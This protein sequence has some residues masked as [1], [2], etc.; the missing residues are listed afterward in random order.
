MKQLQCCGARYCWLLEIV[1]QLQ[2]PGFSVFASRSADSQ[3]LAEM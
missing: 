1:G 2:Q 3:S